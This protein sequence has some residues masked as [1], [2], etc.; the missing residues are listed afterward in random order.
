MHRIQVQLTSDQERMLR[1]L[2]R[3][4]GSSVSALIRE[5]VDY[6]VTPSKENRERRVRS[7]QSIIGVLAGPGDVAGRHDEYYAET[8]QRELRTNRR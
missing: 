3:L 6:V 4:R 5:G 7:A 2:A 8:L 1:E